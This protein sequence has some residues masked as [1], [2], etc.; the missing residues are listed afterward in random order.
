MKHVISSVSIVLVFATG[1][2]ATD[3]PRPPTSGMD[4]PGYI[5]AAVQD[6]ESMYPSA[7]GLV[8]LGTG[9][10]LIEGDEAEKARQCLVEKHG[11][12]ELGPPNW[13][14]GTMA[15]PRRSATN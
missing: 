5:P 2:A 4:M 7:E 15:P 13:R 14:A 12:Y 11:W 6:C 10:F 1:C 8:D 9:Y 3:G